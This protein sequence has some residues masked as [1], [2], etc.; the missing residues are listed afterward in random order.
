MSPR[1]TSSEADSTCTVPKR[2]ENIKIAAKTQLATA[3]PRPHV[4]DD[5]DNDEMPAPPRKKQ[6]Q[7]ASLAPPA[8]PQDKLSAGVT[9][10]VSDATMVHGTDDSDFFSD[11]DSYYGSDDHPSDLER[12]LAQCTGCVTRRLHETETRLEATELELTETQAKLVKA[13]VQRDAAI[14]LQATLKNEL[15]TAEVAK[16]VEALKPTPL[17]IADE[18]RRGFET[19]L[20]ES[21]VRFIRL[22]NDMYRVIGSASAAAHEGGACLAADV[23]AEMTELL[24]RSWRGISA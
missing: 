24:K 5:D 20:H 15:A 6:C 9:P 22:L 11:L 4:S 2:N 19:R 8:K 23:V 18:Q 16:Q 7:S 21:E 10:A 1:N 12:D 17:P 13:E 14:A 3:K